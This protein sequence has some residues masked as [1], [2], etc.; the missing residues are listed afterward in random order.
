ILLPIV[1]VQRDAFI[2]YKN[3]QEAFILQ[4]SLLSRLVRHYFNPSQQPPKPQSKPHQRNPPFY[5]ILI[6][7]SLSKAHNIRN[8]HNTHNAHPTHHP[9]HTHNP[10][11]SNHRIPNFEAIIKTNK[12]LRGR[13]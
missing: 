5:L 8:T 10:N 2:S 3:H 4:L 11:H 9:H 13:W 7:T 1:F 12:R 6:F